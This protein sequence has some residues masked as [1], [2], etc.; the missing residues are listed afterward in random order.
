MRALSPESMWE[1]KSSP[2]CTRQAM[3]PG[4]GLQ[5]PFL[6]INTRTLYRLV[7]VLETLEGQRISLLSNLLCFLQTDVPLPMA[8]PPHL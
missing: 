1:L 5:T 2:C 7:T 3:H 6:L 8:C 4:A